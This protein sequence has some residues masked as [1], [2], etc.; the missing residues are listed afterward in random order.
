[1]KTLDYDLSITTPLV[2]I[3]I[4][5]E[6]LGEYPIREII[7]LS[8]LYGTTFTIQQSYNHDKR[9]PFRVSVYYGYTLVILT[10]K[11]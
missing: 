1:M 4:L 6:I 3:Y 2:Y 10:L 7:K 8:I 9:S 5:L 11:Y